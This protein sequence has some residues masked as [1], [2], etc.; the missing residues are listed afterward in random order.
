MKK[1]IWIYIIVFLTHLFLHNFNCLGQVFSLRDTIIKANGEI[2]ICEIK[3]I[4]NDKLQYLSAGRFLTTTYLQRISEIKFA[5]GTKQYIQPILKITEN[6]WENV[7]LVSNA[8]RVKNLFEKGYVESNNEGSIFTKQ[9]K[10]K[11][12]SIEVIKKEAAKLGAHI[13]LITISNNIK[14]NVEIEND[15][16]IGIR[17]GSKISGIAFGF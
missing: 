11:N 4:E 9:E 13:V 3:S 16:V 12:K 1:N 5:D 8:S 10:L 14:G 2:I 15:Q 6:D 7:Q 17:S